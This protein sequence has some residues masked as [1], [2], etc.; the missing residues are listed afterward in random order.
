MRAARR[1]RSMSRLDV[2]MVAVPPIVCFHLRTRLPHS[3]ASNNARLSNGRRNSTLHRMFQQK[4]GMRERID[5]SF[6][7]GSNS[8]LGPQQSLVRLPL[9]DGLAVKAQA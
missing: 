4:R 1:R 6:A 5:L 8:A 9:H 2:S 7:F 3:K